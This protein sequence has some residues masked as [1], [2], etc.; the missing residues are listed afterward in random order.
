VVQMYNFTAS[1]VVGLLIIAVYTFWLR[2]ASGQQSI[3]SVAWQTALSIEEAIVAGLM[4]LAFY[5]GVAAVLL[6]L[7]ESP[8]SITTWSGPLATLITGFGYIAFDIHLY[9]R[10]QQDIPGA[11]DA[12]RGFVFALLGAGVLATAIG[13]AFA[14]YSVIS[15]ALGSPLDNWQHLA[16]A[17]A[18]AVAVGLVILVVYFV[19][20]NRQKLLART[21]KSAAQME[22]PVT[23][24]PVV[25]AAVESPTVEEV[26]DE[27]LSGKLSR[28]EAAA[29]IRE[30]A[31]VR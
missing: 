1:L 31:G 6:N 10:W 26:L 20:A 28:D 25:T 18:A 13:G 22:P 4:A 19:L 16:R 12:R 17:G 8:V 2:S 27:L 24:A 21:T 3:P 11:R 5:T 7:F 30:I 23:P 29:R 9:R 14:L 15:N